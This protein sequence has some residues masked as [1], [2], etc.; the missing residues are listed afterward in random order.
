MRMRV[1]GVA[2]GPQAAIFRLCCSYS[3]KNQWEVTTVATERAR[4][5]M[6]QK[7]VL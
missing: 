6:Q 1:A 3:S 2:G 7:L 5:E 4:A